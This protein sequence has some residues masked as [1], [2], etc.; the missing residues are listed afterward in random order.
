MTS[1]RLGVP[2]D[3]RHQ[4]S[5]LAGAAGQADDHAVDHLDGIGV[6]GEDL[7]GGFCG[8]NEI[9]EVHDAYRRG[10]GARHDA[11]FGFGDD[12]QGTLG[13]DHH[14]GQIEF[15]V[16]HEGI[17]VIAA[18]APLDRGVALLDLLPVGLNDALDLTIDLVFQ[19][20]RP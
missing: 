15:A 16:A 2:I 7:L 1:K 10:F 9:V 18:D 17:Q 3:E 5:Q 14:L 13:A 4:P 11:H 6:T 12:S 20:C 8:G 19:R